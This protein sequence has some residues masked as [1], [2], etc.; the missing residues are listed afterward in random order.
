MEVYRVRICLAAL[1]GVFCLSGATCQPNPFA[2]PM[3]NLPPALPESPTLDQVLYVVNRQSGQIQS[4]STS[5]ASLAV[6][7][8]PTSLHANIAYERPRRLRLQASLLMSPELD[9][10]SNDEAFWFWIKRSHPPAVYFC[11][12]DQFYTSRAR[13]MTPIEPQ[14][15]VESLGM[16]EF[17]PSMPHQGPFR[18][19]DQRVEVFTLIDTP[20]GP[21]KKISVVDTRMGVVVEQRLQ[22]AQGQLLAASQGSR[23]RRDPLSGVWLPSVVEMQVP[24]ARF[25]LRLDLGPVSVN[26]PVGDPMELFSVP[27]Y[28]DTPLVDIGDP[29][30][31]P[32]MAAAAPAAPPSGRRTLVPVSW[33]VAKPAR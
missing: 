27:R 28:P 23:H 31:Q 9:L 24:P 2:S 10:G 6:A 32:P 29:N 12:H 21:A 5:Q 33:S 8:A 3:A 7:G 15:L 22:D 20:M 4:F 14:W 26:Q 18:M 19:S 17:N 25:G 13:Q 1:L 30:F 11:R 16:V